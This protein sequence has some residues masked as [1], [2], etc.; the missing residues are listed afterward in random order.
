MCLPSVRHW[1]RHWGGHSEQNTVPGTKKPTVRREGWGGEKDTL[2]WGLRMQFGEVRGDFLGLWCLSRITGIG[3]YI[4]YACIYPLHPLGPTPFDL[5]P[6]KPSSW[7][8]SPLSAFKTVALLV[9]RH[10][11]LLSTSNSIG[12]VL[13]LIFSSFFLVWLSP[14]C[15][16]L[17][18]VCL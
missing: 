5:L 15:K 3:S 8:Q 17:S 9:L 12:K 13:S 1:T 6:S 11:G 18:H 2:H 7:R 10:S 16:R 4:P 14:R